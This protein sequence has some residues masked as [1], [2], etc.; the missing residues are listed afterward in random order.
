M[1]PMSNRL[2][3]E[4]LLNQP[5]GIYVLSKRQLEM[6]ISEV[7]NALFNTRETGEKV[8]EM[9]DLVNNMIELKKPRGAF[10]RMVVKI[11]FE[12]CYC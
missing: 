1:E 9:R 5:G 12:P 4:R 3:V 8:A 11:L 6:C 7:N 10:S 2:E